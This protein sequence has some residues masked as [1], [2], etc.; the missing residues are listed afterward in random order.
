[1]SAGFAGERLPDLPGMVRGI[2]GIRVDENGKQWHTLQCENCLAT[3]EP[4][5]LVLMTFKFHA[6]HKGDNPRLCRPCRVERYGNSCN[7]YSCYG[8]KRR[9]TAA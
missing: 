1:V 6:R 7:C 9:E 2:V 4:E 3:E 5:R 8:D